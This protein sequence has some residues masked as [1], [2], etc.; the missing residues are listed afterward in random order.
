MADVLMGTFIPV[1]ADGYDL[2]LESQPYKPDPR[3]VINGKIVLGQE[4]TYTYAGDRNV[5]K[6]ENSNIRKADAFYVE[7]LGIPENHSNTLGRQVSNVSLPTISF[8]NSTQR[9][10][11]FTFNNKG[12]VQLGELGMT[13]Y[14]DV[15]GKVEAILTLQI[16]RQLNRTNDVMGEFDN[17]PNRHYKFGVRITQYNQRNELVRYMVYKDCYISSMDQ[18]DLDVKS[19]MDRSINITIIC[20]DVDI[21]LSKSI[22][23]MIY[24]SPSENVFP[25]N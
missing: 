12:D 7:F 21:Q 8:T 20:D 3:Y 2:T 9:Q 16:L 6:I 15:E 1:E 23:D 17:A 24:V 5:F 14:H 19:G 25:N 18:D 13:F 11:G 10:K 4:T 22:L